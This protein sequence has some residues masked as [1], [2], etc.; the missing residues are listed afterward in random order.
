MDVQGHRGSPD[1]GS[2]ILEN[3]IDAF[4][5]AARFGA[6]GVELDVRLTRDGALAV[7]HGPVIPDVGP[8]ADLDVSQLPAHVPLLDAAIDACAG[9][10]MTVEIKNLPP[11]RDSTPRSG[12]PWP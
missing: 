2:G 6:D 1:P 12:W 8:V 5:R 9:L 11:S 3:T 10:T 4:L 7:H